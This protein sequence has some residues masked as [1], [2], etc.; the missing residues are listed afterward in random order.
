MATILIEKGFDDVL[1]GQKLCRQCVAEYEKLTKP[2]ENEDMTEL[3][4]TE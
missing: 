1:S 3:I 2:P 4:E